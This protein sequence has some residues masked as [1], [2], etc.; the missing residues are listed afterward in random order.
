MTR[1]LPAL[2][3]TLEQKAL[4]FSLGGARFSEARAATYGTPRLAD[5]WDLQ[6]VVTD[7]YEQV[8]WVYKAVE[9][10]S[11]NSS[12]L[13]FT[14]TVGDEEVE[15]HPLLRAMNK[16]ANPAETGRQFRKRLSAQVL[17]SKKGAFVEVTRNRAGQV[18]RLDLLAPDRVRIIPDPS[19]N[20]VSYFEY[21]DY[22]GVV[23]PLPPEKIRWIRE[24][25]PLD[26]FSGVTPLEAAGMS[27][28]LDRLARTY[29]VNFI[30]RD[31]RPGGI[32]GVDTDGLPEE[33]LIRIGNL[34][35]PGAQHAGNV[36][37]IGVGKGG[38]NYIDTSA[39][40]RD[41]A[42]GETSALSRKE[43]L[44]AFGVPESI[45][46]DASDRTFDNAAEEKFTFWH[47]IMLPHLEL[48]AS[49][50]DTDVDDEA[51]CAFDTSSVE[52]LEMPARRR[53]QE[54]REEFDKGL[55]TVKEYRATNPELDIID[56][57]QTRALWMSPAKAPVPGDPADAAELGLGGDMGGMGG[58]PPGA[59]PAA[60]GDGTA[61]SAVEEA[62]AAGGVVSTAAD[63]TAITGEAAAAV[64]QARMG[65]STDS[66]LEGEAAAAVLQARMEGKA[67]E[68]GF[69]I[70]PDT[71]ESFA[72]GGEEI[73]ALER[74]IDAT[75]TGLL[76]RQSGVV[77]AKLREPKTRK[78]TPFWVAEGPED[79]RGG[80]DAIDVS[81]VVDAPR[82]LAE[83]QQALMPVLA[84]AAQESSASLLEAMAA[85]GA[86]AGPAV[87]TASVA[88]RAAETPQATAEQITA[89][90][91]QT[92]APA[93]MLAVTTTLHALDEWLAEN[94]ADL[95]KVMIDQQEPDLPTLVEVVR[96][97]WAEKSPKFID[98]IAVTAAQTIIGGAREAALATLTPAPSA[99]P[100]ADSEWRT[101]EIEPEVIRVWQTREDENVRATHQ[102]A[103][104]QRVGV[105]EP[106]VIGAYDVR[107]PSDPMAPPS[108]AR[109]CRC[110]IKYEW[111]TGATF[112]LPPLAE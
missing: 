93:V 32:V 45:A 52:V 71:N 54:A 88:G 6:T 98:S 84:T 92:V 4:S 11:G 63:E 101:V 29:N 18:T 107:Y 78:G 106:F 19:G 41:M 3:D 37:A 109:Y 90:A 62:I 56:N 36:T 35:K 80:S 24:P 27:V 40:P 82:W 38:M 10:I 89:L 43:I 83:A 66:P 13:P 69:I 64:E 105:R 57:A 96:M 22:A 58:P 110:W 100:V 7:G 30:N 49:A 95:E 16:R 72:P 53:R 102:A 46:G 50:F 8:V 70:R 61:A 25:H 91:A 15:K 99:D 33:E 39:K 75:L 94:A 87:A 73:L 21:T 65:V 81:R 12:R 112:H 76:A 34:F 51:D 59:D 44:A 2:R 5:H 42:Y 9:I 67:I 17:L 47:E 1:W 23:R 86:L 79:T 104:D 26:P 74:K 85:T 48:I 68:P 97:M 60:G 111:T 103:H 77:A 14:I 55:R 28:E 20:Y 31:G 108:V